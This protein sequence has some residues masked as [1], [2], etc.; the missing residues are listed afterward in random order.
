MNDLCRIKPVI[1]E[2]K[3]GPRLCMDMLHVGRVGICFFSDCGTAVTE[4]LIPSGHVVV[5]P[6]L[7][8]LA[9]QVDLFFMMSTQL[10][11]TLENA[12]SHDTQRAKLFQLL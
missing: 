5:H 10:K 12:G 3:F 11:L 6:T 4:D 1:T 9:R 8:G 2:G 7:Y